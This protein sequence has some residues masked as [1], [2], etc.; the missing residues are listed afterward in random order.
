VHVGLAVDGAPVVGAVYQP[1]TE[2]TFCAVAGGGASCDGRPIAVS[3]TDRLD[4]LRLATTRFAPS[5]HLAAFVDEVWSPR[6]IARVGASVKMMSVA[7]GDLEVALCLTEWDTCAPE[8]I[9]REAGGAITDLDGKPFQ[10]N[11]PDPTHPRG[12][13]VSN[14]RL[15][16]ELLELTRPYFDS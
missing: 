9:L 10:Y 3:S 7:S 15:H 16:A 6:A 12:V 1:V 11:R 8:V 4:D 13:L 2:R 14:G 5:A